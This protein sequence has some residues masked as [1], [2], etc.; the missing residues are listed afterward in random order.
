MEK[1]TPELIINQMAE[2]VEQKKSIA[3]SL[4]LQASAKLNVLRGDV[5]DKIYTLEHNLNVEKAELLKDQEMTSAKAESIV[6]ARPEYMEMRKLTAKGKQIDEFIK[7]S[8]KMATLKDLEFN[9]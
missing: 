3:P 6:K 4:W 5:D 2:W 9:Q 1:I 7:I 8:K